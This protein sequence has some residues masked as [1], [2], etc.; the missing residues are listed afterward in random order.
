LATTQANLIQYLIPATNPAAFFRS[1]RPFLL[2]DPQVVLHQLS[3]TLDDGYSPNTSQGQ[4]A[5]SFQG[6]DQPLYFNLT[7]SLGWVVQNLPILSWRGTGVVQTVNVGFPLRN[8]PVSSLVSEIPCAYSLTTNPI[9]SAPPA[10]N[11]VPVLPY[12]IYLRSGETEHALTQAVTTASLVGGLAQSNATAAAS[13]PNVEQGTNECAPGGVLNSLT[14]LN[15]LFHLGLASNA[16]TMTELKAA[17]KWESAGAPAGNPALGLPSWVDNKIQYMFDHNLPIETEQTTNA[18]IAFN[19]LQRH[20]DVEIRV[21]GHV[22]CVVGIT[23][24]GGGRY[25]LLVSHDIVQGQPGGTVVEAVMLDYNTGQVN[26][27]G[28]NATFR[29]F[30]IERPRGG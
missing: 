24:I 8:D 17:L 16:M 30:V 19:A 12:E 20:Y 3:I 18:L 28:W 29:S 15:D 11:P 4:A 5:V 7:T 6:V 13:F 14:Y 26:F 21:Y 23:P 2:F 9:A 1:V 22:A 25:V 10:T 27:P